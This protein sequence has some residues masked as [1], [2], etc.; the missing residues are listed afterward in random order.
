MN[1]RPNEV[2][3]PFYARFCLV[4]LLLFIIG[5]TVYLGSGIIMP[6]L[7]SVFC[8][9]LLRPVVVFLTNRLRFPHVL[10]A[11][12]AVILFLILI[13]AVIFFISSQVSDF[14]NDLPRIRENLGKHYRELQD[15]VS[16]HLHISSSR[17]ENYIRNITK[18]NSNHLVGNTLAGF[19]I[20]LLHAILLPIFTFLI[21][22]YRNLFKKFLSRLVRRRNQ[23]TLVAIVME[24]K[25]V[26]QSY[27]VGLLIEMGIVAALISGGLVLFGV[28]Y[29]LLIGVI[30]ALLNLIPYVGMLCATIVGLVTASINSTEFTV[31]LEVMGVYL[32]V[33]LLDTNFLMPKVVASK[34]RINALASIV[35]VYVGSELA[36]MG[37]MF[38][39]IPTIAIL[40]VIFDRIEGLKPWGILMG[41][42]LP[43]SYDWSS[44]ERYRKRETKEEKVAREVK[45]G[46]NKI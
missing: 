27:I 38:L 20:T 7:L 3:L 8:A 2:Q 21:L 23:Q 5:W 44:H 25:V 28:Q 33:H 41:D 15:W 17:Q 9:I 37:G 14:T 45:K 35:G 1:A 13:G 39:A 43:R 46:G 19:S 30:S 18:D 32:A 26:V 6:L 42:R 36:G 31:S 22:F 16:E 24:V 12:T 34:V 40:K 29:A 10:A 11:L 4:L